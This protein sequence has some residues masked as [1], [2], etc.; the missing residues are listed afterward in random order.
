MGDIHIDFGAL[1]AG[2]AGIQSTF[3]RLQATLDE[4][5][6]GLQ[7]MV[8]SWSGAAQEAYVVC[9]QQ[10]EEAAAALA[11]VLQSISRAVTAAHDNYSAT[12]SAT[13]QIWS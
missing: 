3:A 6:S 9:K 5:E 13:V 10:W 11:A 12:H 2:Q 8:D 4:L 7:P 1:Q